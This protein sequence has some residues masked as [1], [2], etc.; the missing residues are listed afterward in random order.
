MHV[1]QFLKFL[2]FGLCRFPQVCMYSLL[3]S[4][5]NNHDG[6]FLVIFICCLLQLTWL[7]KNVRHKYLFIVFGRVL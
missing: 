1:S 7:E 2:Q 3:T 4:Y 5:T 6:G